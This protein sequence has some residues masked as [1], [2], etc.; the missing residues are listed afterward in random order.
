[1]ENLD[2]LNKQQYPPNVQVVDI[3]TIITKMS[4]DMTFLAVILIIYG[5]ISCL[6]IIGAVFG[7]PYIFAGLRMKEAAEHFRNYVFANSMNELNRA[8]ERQQRLFYIFKV[9]AIIGLIFI[10]LMII[11]YATIF[12]LFLSGSIPLFQNFNDAV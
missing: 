8:I 11:F 10:V 6:T 12:S 9:L 7:V 4:K 5:A 2:N 3:K 1:M